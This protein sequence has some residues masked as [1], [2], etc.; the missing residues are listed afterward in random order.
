[1]C[2]ILKVPQPGHCNSRLS[3]VELC[4]LSNR[5]RIWVTVSILQSGLQP[6]GRVGLDWDEP[7]HVDNSWLKC[8]FPASCLGLPTRG[9]LSPTQ[10]LSKRGFLR[11]CL[12]NQLSK[13]QS[14]AGGWGRR[15]GNRT[16]N[17]FGWSS[18]IKFTIWRPPAK[19]DLGL[20]GPWDCFWP[21]VDNSLT[22]SP[23]TDK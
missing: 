8:S 21:S 14:Q 1:M 23:F 19:E 9:W 6:G 12:P 13:T 3:L 4:C 16:C 11:L 2:I 15:A 10:V 18:K 7:M 20:V 5:H 17:I 22:V